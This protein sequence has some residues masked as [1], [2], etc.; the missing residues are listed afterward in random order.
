MIGLFFDGRF[1]NTTNPDGI[2]RFS[3][4]L[5]NELSKLSELTV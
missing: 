3:I 1:I 4:G 2:T 5:I